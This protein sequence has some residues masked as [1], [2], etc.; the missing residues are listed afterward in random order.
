MHPILK[1]GAAAACVAIIPFIGGAAGAAA[2][3][4]R[5]CHVGAYR[6]TGGGVLD[7]APEGEKNLR[8]RTLDGRTGWLAPD[9]AG[10]WISHYGWTNDIDHIPVSFG[11]CAD[12]KV[13][14]SGRTGRMETL[15]VR[16]TR[17]TSGG[18]TLVGRLVLPRGSSAVPVMVIGHGGEKTPALVNYF[19]QRLYPAEGVGVFV[20]DKRG[21]GQSGGK[22][23]QD[24]N[25]LAGDLAA[26]MTEA[27]RLAGARGSRFGYEAN[28]QGGWVLPLAAAK[29]PADF[30]IIGYGIAATPLVE[31]R[32]ETM[33]D[34]RA[35]GWGPDVLAKAREVTDA[36]ATVM[37]SRFRDGY[38][39]FNAVVAKY[40]G[41]PW[42]KDLNGE[43]TGEMVKHSEAE[44]R[45][46]GPAQDEGT[47]WNVDAVGNLRRLHQ[48]LL[49]LIAADDTQGAGPET[50]LTLAT[51]QAE[52]RP[53]TVAM[54]DKT[55]HGIHLY[56]LGKNGERQETRYARDYFRS[57]LEFARNGRLGL[58]YTSADIWRPRARAP[59]AR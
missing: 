5:D 49:W 41:E 30:M 51:L 12:G 34:L 18:I 40:R 33:Q 21:T 1:I 2:T 59:G 57:E 19:K 25:L 36:T 31:D 20:F 4:G 7:I 54:F 45:I 44:L 17:F 46:G 50:P 38:P 23:T 27:R 11:A 39:A 32:T 37:A 13:R 8:W 55:E 43:F 22:Y 6:L 42:F 53:I 48:P 10:Q 16:E 29:V 28:S 26:A 47:T 9:A 15:E 3:T 52:G 24:F 14:L 35:K 58:I 56:R